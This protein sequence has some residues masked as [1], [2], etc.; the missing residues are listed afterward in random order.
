[1]PVLHGFAEIIEMI[2]KALL[3]LADVEFL[4]IVDKF[5]LEAVLVVVHAFEFFE[6]RFE[7]FAYLGHAALLEG[8]D[9]LHKGGDVVE[10]F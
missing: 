6:A 1:M 8:N 7:A 9:L 4:Y 2:G 3:L 5:L 10:L